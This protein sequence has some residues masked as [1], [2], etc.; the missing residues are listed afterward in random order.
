MQ[1]IFEENKSAILYGAIVWT[2]MLVTD[3]VFAASVCK[4]RF[5]DSRLK[6]FWDPERIF[7]QLLSQTLN[8]KE[9]I[10]WDVYLIYSPE[11]PWDTQLPPVPAFWMHQLNENPDLFFD[12][13]RLKRTVQVMIDREKHE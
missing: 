10:A 3:S 5:S 7:G 13:S 9:S 2:P 6:Q 11:H 4:A 12:P 1:E 8:L